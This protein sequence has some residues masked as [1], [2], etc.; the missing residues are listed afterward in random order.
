[1]QFGKCQH[2]FFFSC[3]LTLLTPNIC[4]YVYDKSGA[5][6]VLSEGTLVPLQQF[7]KK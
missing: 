3:L 1:M 5:F 2:Y 6:I 7:L 4:I